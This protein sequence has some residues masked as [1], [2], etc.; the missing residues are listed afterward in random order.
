MSNYQNNYK[1]DITPSQA[2]QKLQDNPQAKLIDVRTSAEWCFVG[3]PQLGECG[4]QVICIEWVCYPDMSPNADFMTQLEQQGAQEGDELL[5]LCRSGQRSMMAA[6]TATKQGFT[7]CYNISD[8]FEGCP[9][10]TGRRGTISGWK[11]S[12][13]PWKQS[14]RHHTTV[15]PCHYA[16]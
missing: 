13:L 10:E 5:F 3:L 6:I 8:G 7:Q 1:G 12:G 4:K 11:T 14:Q 15:I 16:I 9:D 2:W